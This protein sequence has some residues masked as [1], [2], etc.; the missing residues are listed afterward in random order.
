M[1]AGWISAAEEM[2]TEADADAQGCVLVWHALNG[3]MVTGWHQVA[4]NRYMT[5][6]MRTPAGPDARGEE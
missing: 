3:A 1:A 6:W 2:P 4:R 5:H